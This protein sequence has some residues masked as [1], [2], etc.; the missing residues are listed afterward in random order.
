MDNDP[1]PR[2]RPEHGPDLTA[3]RPTIEPPERIEVNGPWWRG[4]LQ[5]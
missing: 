4:Y 5:G 2:Y 1:E 3:S